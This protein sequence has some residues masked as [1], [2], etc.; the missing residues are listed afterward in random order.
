M[1]RVL[2]AITAVILFVLLFPVKSFASSWTTYKSNSQNNPVVFDSA[3]YQSTANYSLPYTNVSTP[4]GYPVSANGVL[5]YSKNFGDPQVAELYAVN[6]KNGSL[7]WKNNYSRPIYNLSL[8]DNKLYFGAD[9]IYCLNSSDGSEAWVARAG[10]VQNPIY[11]PYVY[12]VYQGVVLAKESYSNF[13]NKSFL[14]LN[15]ENGQIITNMNRY[16]MTEASGIIADGNNFYIS[17][18]NSS[19]GR[20]IA[21]S[22]NTFSK[23][24]HGDLCLNGDQPTIDP[25]HNRIYLLGSTKICIIDS[26]NGKKI[27]NNSYHTDFGLAKY[28]DRMHGFLGSGSGSFAAG[29]DK[30]IMDYGSVFNLPEKFVSPPL[31][32]ND[33]IYGGSNK[34]RIWSRNLETGEVKFSTIGDSDDWVYHL[35]YADGKIIAITRNDRIGANLRVMDKN[36]L[37]VTPQNY[38]VTLDSPYKT[39]GPYLPLLGQLHA[40]YISDYDLSA[41]FKSWSKTPVDVANRYLDTGYNF[42]AITEHDAITQSLNLPG[43]LDVQY[44]EE[45]TEAPS[46]HHI[47]AIGINS[48]INE[49]NPDQNRVNQINE[50][51]GLAFL[52]HPNAN[53]YSE[54]S[55]QLMDLDGY[56]GIEIF[57][58][59][60]NKW[61][62][63]AGEPYALDKWDELLTSGKNIWATSG[64]DYTPWDGAFDGGAVVVFSKTKS[65][66]DIMQNLKGGNF[67]ALQGSQAPRIS[68]ATSGNQITISSDRQSKIKFIGNGGVTLKTFNDTTVASYTATGDEIY[69]RAEVEANGKTAWTQPI[70]V[71]KIR[72]AQSVNAGAHYISLG[73]AGLNS[74]ATAPVDA[75]IIPSSQYPN[76]SPPLGYLSSVYS[77][78]T[79]G[80]ILEGTKL[81]IS[82]ADRNIATSANNLAI[83]TYN[84]ATSVWDKVESF[85]DT[86]NKTVTANLQHFSL[87][88]LS[89]EQPADTE[90]PIVSL[91]LP[92]DL[93][94]LSGQIGFE[95]SASDNN[96]VTEVRFIFDD[97]VITKDVD[98]S[99]GWKA[100]INANDF[101]TGS[102]KLKLEAEDFAGNIGTFETN[103]T[104]ASSTF[105]APTIS[106]LAPAN[107]QYLK[108]KFIISGN[109]SSQNE[110]K[111][112]SVYLNDIYLSDAD[113]TNG[114]YQKEIDFSQFKEGKH[115]LKAV[116]TDIKDN[117]AETAITINVGDELKVSII[118]PQNKT[119]LHAGSILFKY[120][121][122]PANAS[123]VVTKIDGKE[124][125]NNTTKNAY[126]FTLGQHKFTV[127]KNGKVYAETNF[128]ISTSLADQIKL[129]EIMFKTGHI[130][131]RGVTTAIQVQLILAQLFEKLKM[132]N[133]R[134]LTIQQTIKYINQQNKQKKPLI[135]NYAKTLLVNDLIYLLE[136]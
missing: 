24:W 15:A 33:T 8:Y 97:K 29:D 122:T 59:G 82:Y 3:Q 2:F 76:S 63:V 31:I 68:V 115:V 80:Q 32:V 96:A 66:S 36:D 119:Y 111:N 84:E 106:L 55:E 103:F 110:V 53:I 104:I 45:D 85:V 132:K 130:K 26:T 7:I 74:N 102:H 81:S 131:N 37:S 123:G 19:G 128:T 88:T 135:D 117:I 116:L 38:T 12:M 39:D 69:I 121:T 113:L 92:T 67:Y 49:N 107:E 93:T 4:Y 129:T 22:I 50:Q 73:Q 5:Y 87:Y 43:I 89:A 34:G 118:S 20:I 42:I 28:G 99:N 112:I 94:N 18:R 56:S 127:E 6:I 75:T 71:N 105:I 136:R 78:A 17:S 108:D 10:L 79:S 57:N 77:F 124:I 25:E 100:E 47:L 14:A 58:S 13:I 120:Q 35:I 114:T 61:Y 27:I 52:S 44:S 23:I 90:N 21:F 48:Q 98:I 40:H 30:A 72:S 86:A 60:V 1:K 62:L 83:Y 126:D 91:A 125:A 54:N 95:A 41:I 64:D 46:K 70:K 11:N 134:N 109:Y 9:N 16:D 51:G 101:T 65:Q 133:L